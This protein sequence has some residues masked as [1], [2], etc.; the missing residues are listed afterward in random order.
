ME[1]DVK[2]FEVSSIPELERLVEAVR[3]T[4]KP[5][6]LTQS[7]QDVALVVPV[8]ASAKPRRRAKSDVQAHDEPARRLAAGGVAAKRRPTARGK[9]MTADD[10]FWQLVGSATDAVPTDAAKKHEYLA[11]H[12]TRHNP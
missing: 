4:R 10:P 8:P 12:L 2:R 7:G 5:C 1:E 3:R 6:C 11:E 9:P